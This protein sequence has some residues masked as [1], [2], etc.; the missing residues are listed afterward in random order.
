MESHTELTEK[1]E[2]LTGATT[3]SRSLQKFLDFN[4]WESMLANS[5]LLL[6]RR[7]F[8][9]S[10]TL[11]GIVLSV[12]IALVI[13]PWYRSTLTLMPPDANTG[14]MAGMLALSTLADA[15]GPSEALSSLGLHDT[16]ALFI[17]ILHSRTVQDRIV[18]RFQLKKVYGVKLDANA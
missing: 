7:R 18:E 16:G 8:L 10:C 6:A 9:I 15:S 4:L 1:S 17:D 12:V 13:P 3:Q 5:R 14:S 2:K 11:T